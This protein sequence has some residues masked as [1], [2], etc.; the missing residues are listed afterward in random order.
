MQEEF[1]QT[2]MQTSGIN[3]AKYRL[4]YLLAKIAQYVEQQAFGN[5]E[6]LDFYLDKTIT[7]EHIMPQSRNDPYCNKLGNLTLLE[8]TLN[9]SI[10]DKSYQDKISGYR[11]SKILIT[12]SLADKLYIGNNTRLN[13][14]MNELGLVEFI[15]WNYDSINK[16]QQILVDIAMKVWGLNI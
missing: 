14:A 11:Q 9:S 16:R 8:K 4:R 1:K 7:I 2:I 12:R 5:A 13:R 6:S 15:E 3:L 10:S